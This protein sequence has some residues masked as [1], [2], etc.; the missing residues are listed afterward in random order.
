MP[1]TAVLAVPD[2]FPGTVVPLGSVTDPPCAEKRLLLATVIVSSGDGGALLLPPPQRK[3]YSRWKQRSPSRNTMI[4]RVA[5]ATLALLLLTALAS[6]GIPGTVNLGMQGS[7]SDVMTDFTFNGS[8]ST[9]GPLEPGE[10]VRLTFVISPK[11]PFH[12]VTVRYNIPEGIDLV[13]GE[14][15]YHYDSLGP[16]DLRETNA[17][18][19]V[20]DD[21][22]L[23]SLG[24]VVSRYVSSNGTDFNFGESYLFYHPPEKPWYTKVLES[25]FTFFFS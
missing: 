25:V 8:T 3:I 20:T 22:H 13:D 15:E 5:V 12:N 10:I 7:Q 17:V 1:I 14:T 18:V 21:V 2:V 6:A 24:V 9:S 11:F 23:L 19:N 4:A 16:G